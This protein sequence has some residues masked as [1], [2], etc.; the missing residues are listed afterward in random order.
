[1][2]ERL[3]N[4][5]YSCWTTKN[6]NELGHPPFTWLERDFADFTY[7][8]TERALTRLLIAGG[9]SRA[10][11]WLCNSEQPIKYHLKVK[12]TY[13]ACEEPFFNSNNQVDM[14]RLMLAGPRKCWISFADQETGRGF[15][16][17]RNA[18]PSDVYIVLR[19][20]NLN[21]P[22][23]TPGFKV[24]MDPWALYLEGGLN[25]MAVDKYA[26]TPSERGT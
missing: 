19:V 9:Y 14:V 12:S 18:C 5:D 2:S 25:F 6:R 10:E 3:P 15:T 21:Q 26:V 24:Y 23:A 4:W 20:Y 22:S 7:M 8:D 13:E 1:M 17:P 11:E 16:L